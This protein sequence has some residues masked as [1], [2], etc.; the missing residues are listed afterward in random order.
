[1][2]IILNTKFMAKKISELPVGSPIDD[3]DYTI[4]YDVETRATK[5][6]TKLDFK[7]DA[8]EPG[9][10]GINSSI[11]RTFSWVIANPA[12][13]VI[14]GPRLNQAY[15]ITRIDSSVDIGSVT[16]N[17]NERENLTVAGSNILSASQVALASGVSSTSF[18]DSSIAVDNWLA[19]NI[20]SISSVPTQ[21]VVTI[22]ATT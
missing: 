3:T 13:G 16:F 19:L 4:F 14:Y 20:S 9:A 6:G 21:L 18:N 7:G 12:S 22:S 10:D 11:V 2:V 15:T 8:G 1:M 17:V 5:R